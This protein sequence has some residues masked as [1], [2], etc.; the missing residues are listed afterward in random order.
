MEKMVKCKACDKEIAKSAKVCPHCGKKQKNKGFTVIAV[1]LIVIGIFWA[2]GDG[3]TAASNSSS[4]SD[5][6]LNIG[7]TVSTSKIEL[8]ITKAKKLNKVGSEYFESSPSEGAI[9]VAIDY[10][11]KN[12][13][14]EPLS[15]WNQPTVSLISPEKTKYSQ[16]I[17]ASGYYATEQDFDEKVISDL[18]PGI[19]V[20]TAVVF[21]VS[22]EEIAKEG[23]MIDIDGK[24]VLLKF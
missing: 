2:I 4:S 1:I 5:T 9:Y 12:I 7:D 10:K 6:V 17:S 20:K 19:T 3:E 21:E 22:K 8:N 14:K 11:Y 16:D 23:W 24:K 15:M 18:N 13:S